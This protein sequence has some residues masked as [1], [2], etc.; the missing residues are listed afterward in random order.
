ML[1]SLSLLAD[2]PFWLPYPQFQIPALIVLV[3]VIFFYVRWKKK[4]V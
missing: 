4:Q 3:V 2:W 1:S